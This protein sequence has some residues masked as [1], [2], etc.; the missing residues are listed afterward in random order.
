M[1]RRCQTTFLETTWGFFRLG[2]HHLSS[3]SFPGLR[4]E[5]PAQS[6]G[7]RLERGLCRVRGP[8]KVTALGNMFTRHGLSSASSAMFH[9][10]EACC[11]STPFIFRYSYHVSTGLS[12]FFNSASLP[13]SA[14]AIERSLNIGHFTSVLSA[15]AHCPTFAPEIRLG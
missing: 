3:G 5:D 7:R 9:F 13:F 2:T 8:R 11:L 1:A 15:A 14:F 12:I 10:L 6:E 4:P